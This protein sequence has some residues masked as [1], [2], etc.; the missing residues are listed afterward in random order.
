VWNGVL[1]IFMTA[2]FWFGGFNVVPQVLGE[3]SPGT[4]LRR[5]G[6]MI[7]LSILVGIAFKT[8]V[9]LSASMTMPWQRLTTLDLPVA[10]AFEVAFGSTMLAKLV[11][12]AALFGL[13]STWNS[14]L[15]SGSRILFALGRA[16]IIAP[17]FGAVH[18]RSGAPSKAVLFTAALATV[19]TLLGREALLPIVNVSSACLA[20][21]YLLT[22]LAVLKL[23][24]REPTRDRPYRVP[25]GAPTVWVGVLGS[26][27]TLA[28]ALYQ[29]WAGAKGRLPLEWI[30]LGVWL[31]IGAGFW[32]AAGRLRGQMAEQDRRRAIMGEY[33]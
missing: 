33:A 6:H 11:L 15:V 19:G 29:P 28:L 27:A 8:L 22:C 2:A 9:V 17:R 14:V 26:A 12:V 24:R 23:R 21:A 4:P 3:R 10:A 18:P 1:S 7:L 25:G 5:I 31:L 30:I 32:V 13:L 16:S 20:F